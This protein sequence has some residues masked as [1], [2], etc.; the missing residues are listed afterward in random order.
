MTQDATNQLLAMLN[1]A[2]ANMPKLK[3]EEV[4]PAAPILSRLSIITIEWNEGRTDYSGK[5]CESWNAFQHALQTIFDDYKA[6]EAGGY[7]KVKASI[8]WENGKQLVDRIDVGSH[9]GDFNPDEEFI[10]AYL[11]RQ[12]TCMYSGNL[13]EGDRLTILS[14]EDLEEQPAP[15]PA[16]QVQQPAPPAPQPAVAVQIQQPAPQ[17]AD[18]PTGDIEFIEYSDK[19]F[20][21]FGDRTKEHKDKLS[22]FGKWN[23]WLTYCNT[24][25]F[26]WIFA[27]KYRKDV[28][29]ILSANESIEF[30]KWVFNEC[31][32]P[33]GNLDN[34]INISTDEAATLT[35]LFD[36]FKS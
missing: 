23:P 22:K 26:G 32:Q 13:N 5:S 17:P 3:E 27:N 1:K 2:Q 21:V 12:K 28:E 25:R 30:I 4:K 18:I 15:Q 14:F 34:W 31:W 33:E 9:A 8:Q 7:Y 29:A 11:R 10:G 6:T 19:S 20:A 35:D 24:K 36:K 16:V